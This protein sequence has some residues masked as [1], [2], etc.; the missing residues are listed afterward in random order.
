M[1]FRTVLIGGFVAALA[2]GSVHMIARVDA[3][4]E[5]KGE[6]AQNTRLDQVPAPVKATIER[7]RAGGRITQISQGALHGQTAYEVKIAKDG[8]TSKVYVA[9]DG[10]V[11]QRAA[12]DDDDDD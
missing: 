5:E 11:L 1:L 8:Q 3:A 10:T 2:C 7:E 9:A 4:G 6:G 12:D